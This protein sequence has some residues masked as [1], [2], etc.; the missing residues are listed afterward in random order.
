M[1][2]GGLLGPSRFVLTTEEEILA[3]CGTNTVCLVVG[4]RGVNVRTEETISVNF[5]LGGLG[6]PT[7]H[8]RPAGS[9]QI[10]SVS[11]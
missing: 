2:W 7:S 9:S 10:I 3:V 1:V 11:T 4:A 8:V 6:R 5:V